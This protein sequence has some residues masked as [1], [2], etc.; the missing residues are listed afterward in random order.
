[1][2]LKAVLDS[3]TPSAALNAAAKAYQTRCA[4]QARRLELDYTFKRVKSWSDLRVADKPMDVLPNF[5]CQPF[6]FVNLKSWLAIWV[7]TAAA[8][9]LKE[10][11]D[12]RAASENITTKFV[13]A[14]QIVSRKL[15]RFF[16]KPRQYKAIDMCIDILHTRK[17]SQAVVVPLEG[18]EGKS[19]IGWGLV[20]YW[21]N[22]GWFGHPCAHLINKAFFLTKSSVT[23]NMT[24]RARACG[25]ANV[26]QTV[27][28]L[29]HTQLASNAWSCYFREVEVESYGVNTKVYEYVLPPPAII[30]IDECQDYKKPTSLKSKYLAALVRKGVEC[31]SVFIFMSATPWVTINDT[32]LFCIA[33]GREFHGEKI[34]METFPAMARAIA[35]QAGVAPDE[36]DEK[37]MQA[38][39]REF[40]DC[41]VIPPR[42]PRKFKA[43]NDVMLVDFESQAQRDFYNSTMARYDDER[44]RMGKDG[45]VN[46]MTIF[47]K[48]RHAEERI[49]CPTFAKL[50]AASEKAGFAPVIGVCTQDAVKEITRLLVYEY[51]YKRSDIS[52]IW[53]G[54][55]II[56]RADITREVGDEFMRNI[57]S[58]VVRYLQTPESLT[59]DEITA[60]RKYLQWVK[61]QARFDEDETQQAGRHKELLTLKLD[62]QSLD[63][64]QDEIDRFQNG[65]TKFCIF[66]L[67]AGGV[68]VDLDQQ[69]EHVRPREGFFTICYWAEEFMQALYRTM[70]IATLSNVRQHIVFFRGTIV[71]SHVAP[72]LDKKIKSVRAATQG[73][74]EF[75]DEI[76]DLLAGDQPELA[77]ELDE[78]KLTAGELTE[79][80]PEGFDPDELVEELVGAKD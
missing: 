28:V 56:S 25:V 50:G 40:N 71:A 6:N 1:M 51:G 30:I 33:T 38:F 48:K 63:Q 8:R 2:N 72:K 75:V 45:E 39:R 60:T 23:I 17:V 21:Q 37:A 70:R 58:Y 62:R 80:T 69:F 79:E 19:V 53:G 64:R 65:D 78:S 15:G 66:T 46:K 76:V 18:G 24:R 7:Q 12:R 10:E 68:G 11:A 54:E 22:N 27:M 16:L 5:S 14:E 77:M 13:A 74:D 57:G 47:G 3:N 42:D 26:N 59:A 31:G 29:S 34:T 52:V 73:S 43:M 67:S 41:Y 35:A 4:D 49:K 9:F 61:E 20:D 36:H 44:R 32:W 55:K